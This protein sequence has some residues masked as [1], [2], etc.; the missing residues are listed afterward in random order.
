MKNV[1]VVNAETIGEV[2][3]KVL[4]NDVNIDDACDLLEDAGWFAVTEEELPEFKVTSKVVYKV[5]E[6]VFIQTK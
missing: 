1:K 6:Y 5:D 2:A 3:K 4:G